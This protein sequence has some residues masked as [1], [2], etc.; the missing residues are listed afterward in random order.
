MQHAKVEH[1]QHRSASRVKIAVTV[2]VLT[3]TTV[4]RIVRQGNHQRHLTPEV[5][6]AAAVLHHGVLVA[7]VPVVRMAVEAIPVAA[8]PVAVAADVIN[9]LAFKLFDSYLSFLN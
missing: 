5:R 8:V 1:I 4:A 6:T 2:Q 7:A 3:I 9:V